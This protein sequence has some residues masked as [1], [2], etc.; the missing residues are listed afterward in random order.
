VVDLESVEGNP[1]IRPTSLSCSSSVHGG[2]D[3]EEAEQVIRR[4]RDRAWEWMRTMESSRM[5][6]AAGKGVAP[7]LTPPALMPATWQPA[8][9]NRSP[10]KNTGLT[11]P[12]DRS[13]GSC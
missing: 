8:M 6:E 11:G 3:E 2:M 12:Q 13:D 5:L 9:Q 10:E 1:W 4:V 7:P